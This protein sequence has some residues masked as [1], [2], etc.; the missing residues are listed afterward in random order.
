GQL[1]DGSTT[2]QLLCVIS[3]GRLATS[4]FRFNEE[5]EASPINIDQHV[6]FAEATV[7]LSHRWPEA[8]RGMSNGR[9]AHERQ[10]S[11]WLGSRA[12]YD[13]QQP[14]I[15]TLQGTEDHGG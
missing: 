3:N 12:Q 10:G 5:Q 8:V 11:V 1:I 7:L 6:R 14:R 15:R 2:G 13:A 4:K 9:Q